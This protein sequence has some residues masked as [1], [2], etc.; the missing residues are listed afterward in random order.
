ML[1]LV[2]YST[3]TTATAVTAASVAEGLITAGTV[4][5]CVDRTVKGVKKLAKKR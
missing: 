4:A 1:G 2:S 5:T 3:A